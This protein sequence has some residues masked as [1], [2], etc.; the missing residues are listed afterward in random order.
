MAGKPIDWNEFYSSVGIPAAADTGTHG[1]TYYPPGKNYGY[2]ITTG[3]YEER[4][5]GQAYATVPAP[6]GIADWHPATT[7]TA[8]I[9]T[10]APPVAAPASGVALGYKPTS[11]AAAPV[12]GKT[13]VDSGGDPWAGLRGTDAAAEMADGYGPAPPSTW[14]NIVN[15]AGSVLEHTALGGIISKIFPDQWASMGDAVKGV[16]GGIG[17]APA[18]YKDP[19]FWKTSNGGS[20][21]DSIGR[22]SPEE[23]AAMGWLG[24]RRNG[25]GGNGVTPSDPIPPIVT[26]PHTPAP[27][28][29]TGGGLPSGIPGP[30]GREATFPDMPPYRPGIDPEHLYFRNK[31]ADG[32]IVGYADGGQVDM[33]SGQDPRVA[34]IADTEDVLG[35]LASGQKPDQQQA[36]TLKQFVAQFGDEALRQLHGSVGGGMSMRGKPRMVEGPGGPRDD[37]IPAR[38]N[39]VEEAALSD[40][41]FVMPAAAVAAVGEGDPRK[42]AEKLQR[43]SEQLAGLETAPLNVERAG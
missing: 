28:T 31:M 41:E 29:G 36:E 24:Q 30:K 5:P 14:D 11:A 4:A 16:G 19:G 17:G 37:A 12:T 40:G 10:A 1:T 34:L 7:A 2:N 22:K 27:T 20:L 38:V 8:A 25:K 9:N 42:G 3:N 26:D 32:G 18:T 43:L 15:G 13:S 6:A 35:A 21:M 39:G 23:K 33:L